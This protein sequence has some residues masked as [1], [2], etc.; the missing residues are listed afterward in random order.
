MFSDIEKDKINVNF[1]EHLAITFDTWLKIQLQAESWK[2]FSQN[3]S[4]GWSFPLT[5]R[6]NQSIKFM[7]SSMLIDANLT[8]IQ[9]AHGLQ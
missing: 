1:W 7:F 9:E 3:K 4:F 2:W 8:T 6:L 5:K